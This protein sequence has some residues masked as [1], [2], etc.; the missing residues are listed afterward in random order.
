MFPLQL[1][2]LLAACVVGRK[3]HAVELLD[4]YLGVL[5]GCA[6]LV[7]AVADAGLFN[8]S[9]AADLGSDLSA[10]RGFLLEQVHDKRAIFGGERVQVGHIVRHDV[11]EALG[12]R[13][14][15]VLG[16]LWLAQSEL[17]GRLRA[18]LTEE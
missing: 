13:L 8:C 17:A 10:R 6:W 16:A 7:I 9:E 18:H 5:L 3:G 15:R 12:L 1:Y 11:D 2:L 4:E 14:A